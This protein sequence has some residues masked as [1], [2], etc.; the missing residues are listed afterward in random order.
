MQR[1]TFRFLSSAKHRRFQ[2]TPSM[3]RATPHYRKLIAEIGISIHALYAEGDDPAHRGSSLLSAISI[4]ALYAEGDD[5]VSIGFTDD[6][7]SIHALYA[8]G[9][10][11][12]SSL[13]DQYS[14]FQSTP[15]MQ[16]ATADIAKLM[17]S[18]ANFN[19]RPLCRGRRFL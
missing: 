16:R 5:S 6:G 12:C 3:Q 19:P 11:C 1:A 4:H 2:S 8:E 17:G 10:S 15:S 18:S 14:A 7:I 9:D 13:I